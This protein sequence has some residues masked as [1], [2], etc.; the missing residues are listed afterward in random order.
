MTEMHLNRTYIKL[1]RNQVQ[2]LHSTPTNDSRR[3]SCLCNSRL[4]RL[5]NIR[6]E[7]LL[8]L[9]TH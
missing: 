4:Q 3:H 1:R 2:T 9:H 8:L 7:V 5:L 6:N